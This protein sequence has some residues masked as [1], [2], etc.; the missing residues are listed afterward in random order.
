MGLTEQ[1]T[2]EIITTG[3]GG[4]YN[5]DNLVNGVKICSK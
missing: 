2:A 3:Y 4:S 5:K 1:E